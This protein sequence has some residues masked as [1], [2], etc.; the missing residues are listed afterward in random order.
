MSEQTHEIEYFIAIQAPEEKHQNKEDDWISVITGM[1]R[2]DSKSY[3]AVAMYNGD[4]SVYDFNDKL[5][6]K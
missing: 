5:L 1:P 2:I 3:Y 4:V 6:F